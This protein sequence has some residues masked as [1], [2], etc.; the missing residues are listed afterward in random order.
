M[1]K[2]SV[3]DKVRIVNKELTC[4]GAIGKIYSMF[5]RK[6]EIL[7]AIKV[8]REEAKRIY[9]DYPEDDDFIWQFFR[10]SDLEKV[11]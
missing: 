5:E 1:S 4:Y 8:S 6:G 11:S 3:G 10:E 9:P 2:F 7:Y